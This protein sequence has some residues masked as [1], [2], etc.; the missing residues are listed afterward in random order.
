M[1]GFRVSP[2]MN[3]LIGRNS[4]TDS[5]IHLNPK[6][7]RTHNMCGIFCYQ[8]IQQREGIKEGRKIKLGVGIKIGGELHERK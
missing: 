7:D 4:I 5:K 8:G 1:S 2:L 3:D 6:N